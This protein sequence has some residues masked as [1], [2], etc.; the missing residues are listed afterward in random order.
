MAMVG[1]RYQ[2]GSSAAGWHDDIGKLSLNCRR[3]PSS[4]PSGNNDSK[5][6]WHSTHATSFQRLDE[7]LDPVSFELDDVF[8]IPINNADWVQE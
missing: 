5:L 4:Y 2:H 7:S 6:L 1:I 3:I 8:T